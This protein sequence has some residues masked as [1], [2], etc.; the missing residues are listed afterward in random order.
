MI[1]LA[2]LKYKNKENVV[3]NDYKKLGAANVTFELLR[4]KHN[5]AIDFERTM[6]ETST[7][8]GATFILYNVVRL[9][10]LLASFDQHVST[11]FYNALPEYS[12]INLGLL[13]E[14]VCLL[15]HF[16]ITLYILKFCVASAVLS[17]NIF[18]LLDHA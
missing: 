15:F 1:K 2:E 12:E 5:N 11:G 8:K 6:T 16:F 10:C 13:K 9:Q 7:I 17:R 18:F 3:S 4:V 14:E